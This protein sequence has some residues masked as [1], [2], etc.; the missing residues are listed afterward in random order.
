[1]RAASSR[2]APVGARARHTGKGLPY[3]A[4]PGAAL[5]CRRVV[6][7]MGWSRNAG[8]APGSHA[9][10]CPAQA[11]YLGCPHGHAGPAVPLKDRRTH[12]RFAFMM[13]SR[14]VEPF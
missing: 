8:Q 11:P 12:L 7:G 10:P 6:T 13:H 1:M 2:S 14:I 9:L 4:L 5:L 3:C